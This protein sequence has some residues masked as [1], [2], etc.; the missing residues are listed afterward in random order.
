MIVGCFLSLLQVTEELFLKEQAGRDSISG[1]PEEEESISEVVAI[2][3][4]VQLL[5]KAVA[6]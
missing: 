3:A 4:G 2:I 5:Y 6:S 1:T